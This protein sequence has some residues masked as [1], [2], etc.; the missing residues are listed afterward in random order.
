MLFEHFLY[1]FT[2]L[3]RF[4]VNDTP[5]SIEILKQ[6][7]QLSETN[8]NMDGMIK[9]PENADK[10]DVDP[11]NAPREHKASDL[12]VESTSISMPEKNPESEK[13]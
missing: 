7:E 3:V 4:L 5:R 12:A 9:P 1:F 13:I 10:T 2:G 6:Q 8:K 11:N